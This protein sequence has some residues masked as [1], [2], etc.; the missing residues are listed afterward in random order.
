[1]SHKTIHT[2]P[3]FL[4]SYITNC[5]NKATLSQKYKLNPLCLSQ[6]SIYF[7]NRNKIVKENE[8]KTNIIRKQIYLDRQK[9]S[10]N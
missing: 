6:L 1:M 2:D 3:N 5:N 9:L 7:A 10:I 4:S 8:Q